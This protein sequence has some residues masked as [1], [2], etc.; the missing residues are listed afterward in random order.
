MS[1]EY[2]LAH[3]PPD[4]LAW[5]LLG[6]QCGTALPLP[7]LAWCRGSRSQGLAGEFGKPNRWV[8]KT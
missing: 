6:W 3:F 1:G 5:S 8:G 4:R 2:L 7:G